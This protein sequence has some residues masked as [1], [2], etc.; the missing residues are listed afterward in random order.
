MKKSITVTSGNMAM[1]LGFI[2]KALAGKSHLT[3]RNVFTNKLAKAHELLIANPGRSRVMVLDENGKETPWALLGSKYQH[4]ISSVKVKISLQE[5]F[6]VPE[7]YKSIVIKNHADFM[8]IICVGD[9]VCIKHQGIFI[10][11]KNPRARNP[12]RA[13]L[14]N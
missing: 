4:S 5:N 14:F 8:E 12:I 6:D 11:S 7:N 13:L 1:V 9:D 2:K 3:S 10:L